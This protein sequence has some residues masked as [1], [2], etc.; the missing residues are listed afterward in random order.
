[1]TGNIRELLPLYALGVLEVDEVD[2]VERALAHDPSL[3]TE[4]ASHHDV[5]AVLG[6]AGPSVPP[7]PHVLQRLMTSVGGGRFEAFSARLA[8]LFDV[9]VERAREL[10]GLIDRPE[11]WRPQLPGIALVHFEGGP[12]TA[13]ADCG[14][15]RID[16]GVTFPAHTHLGEEVTLV[17][18]GQFRDV[19]NNLTS[20][21]GDDYLQA[22]GTT[23]DLTCVSE[24]ACLYA[25]RANEGVSMFGVRV[26]PM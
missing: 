16:P 26:R 25:T 19:A 10:L 24:E 12:A 1:M 23:H 7:A 2:A 18:S 6:T 15:V 13:G 17:L 8:R 5:A 11:S 22:A 20:S 9:T 14:F 3:A 4:L 21:P